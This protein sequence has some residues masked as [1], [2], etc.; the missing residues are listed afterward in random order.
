MTKSKTNS[1]KA[2]K[3]IFQ[4]QKYDTDNNLIC[5]LYRLNCHGNRI[6]KLIG[7]YLFDDEKFELNWL[8]DGWILNR[9]HKNL[10]NFFMSEYDWKPITKWK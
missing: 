8:E 5:Y 4:P 9:S 7:T 2:G 3:Y 10:I 1:I 6:C